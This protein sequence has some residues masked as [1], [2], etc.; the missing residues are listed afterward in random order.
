MTV[1]VY[2]CRDHYISY[3]GCKVIVNHQEKKIIILLDNNE[4]M[5]DYKCIREDTNNLHCCIKV[6]LKEE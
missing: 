3:Y 2:K 6:F 1:Y 4:I 5:Y